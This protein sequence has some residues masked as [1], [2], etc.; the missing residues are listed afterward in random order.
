M[1]FAADTSAR[2]LREVSLSTPD[3]GLTFRPDTF[4]DVSTGADPGLAVGYAVVPLEDIADD[5]VELRDK[6]GVSSFVVTWFGDIYVE[7]AAEGGGPVQ[8]ANVSLSH[9]CENADETDLR[10]RRREEGVATAG[11][12]WTVP[13]EYCPHSHPRSPSLVPRRLGRSPHPRD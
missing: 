6:A 11:I 5:L 1:P 7:V 4:R 2:L 8:G 13:C 3:C 9:L 10:A 12:R